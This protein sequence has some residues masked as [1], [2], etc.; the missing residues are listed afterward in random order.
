MSEETLENYVATH[1]INPRI[2]QMFLNY[3]SPDSKTFNNTIKSY[4]EAG[5]KETK[6]SKYA[7]VAAYQSLVFKKL[8]ELHRQKQIKTQERRELTA[9]EYTRQEL[10]SVIEAAKDRKDISNW[11]GAVMDLAKLD[12][13]LADRMIIGRDDSIA[14]DNN[15]RQAALQLADRMLLPESTQDS[16]ERAIEADIAQ[17]ARFED[18]EPV[19]STETM[20]DCQGDKDNSLPDDWFLEDDTHNI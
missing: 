3:T 9:L 4:Y 8:L 11:R 5:Y 16:A 14:I 2:W 18:I 6:T 13:L 17:D 20:Q 1:K 19:D 15:L 12:G 7:A 10:Q